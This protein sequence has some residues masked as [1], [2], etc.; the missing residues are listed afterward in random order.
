[1]TS[2][3]PASWPGRRGGCH[4]LPARLR[5]QVGRG[6]GASGRRR[7]D[8]RRR[9]R[10]GPGGP[11]GADLLKG[12]GVDARVIDMHTVKPLDEALVLKAAK[13]TGAIVTTE[14][15]NIIGGRLRRGR[16]SRGVYPVPVVRHGVNDEFGRSGKAAEVLE[17]YGLTAVG[18]VEKVRAALALK[19]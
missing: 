2:R 7:R 14:E 10:Y 13:E 11:E 4:L 15:H 16:L 6:R 8:H 9:G 5:L 1:M 18:I 3:L 17:A 19:R 12:E